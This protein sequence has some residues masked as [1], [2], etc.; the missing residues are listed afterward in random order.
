[1]PTFGVNNFSKGLDTKRHLISSEAGE[2]QDLVN[3]HVN[4]GG[5]IEKRR[6][7][8]Q[9]GTQQCTTVPGTPGTDGYYTT[10]NQWVVDVPGIPATWVV[11][12]PYYQGDWVV[13]EP[14]H[15]D[16]GQ[17]LCPG[18]AGYDPNNSGANGGTTCYT[19]GGE[20]VPEVG[21]YE[22]ATDEQ[23]HW[24]GGQAEVG[25]WEEEQIWHPPVPG[26]PDVTTCVPSNSLPPGTFG[27]EITGSGIFVFGSIPQ[28]TWT[29]PQD[30]V[31]QRLQH[32]DGFAMTGVRWS[33][34]YGAKP[35]VLAEF[36]NG[37]V[38]PYYNG[39]AVGSFVN[40]IVRQ[41]MNNTEGVVDHFK[42]LFDTAIAEALAENSVLKHYTVSKLNPTT[43]RLTGKQGVPF[44]VSTEAEAPMTIVAT[45]V[46]EATDDVLERV[47]VARVTISQGTNGSARTS[48][49]HRWSFYY[50]GEASWTPRITGIWIDEDDTEL[51]QLGPGSPGLRADTPVFG[52]AA[53]QPVGSGANNMAKVIAYYINQLTET[54]E[55][56]AAY[57]YGG[58]E[59][60]AD[61]GTLTI[62]AP[63][64]YAESGNDTTIWFEFDADPSPWAGEWS[65]FGVDTS[66]IQVS[67][68]NPGRWYAKWAAAF[69]GGA[70]NSIS[71]FMVESTELMKA[72]EDVY[73]KTS[74]A[75][76]ADDLVAAINENLTSLDPTPD[77]ILS[78]ENTSTIVVTARPGTGASFNG[79]RLYVSTEGSVGTVGNQAFAGGRDGLPGK[80]QI[81]DFTFGGFSL[82][83]KLTITITDSMLTGYP[84]Q[85]GASWLAGKEPSFT[86]TYKA[87][88]FAGIDY[89][90][91][92]S[93]LNDCTQWD[94]YDNGAG[95]INL[96][97]NFSGRDPLTGVGVY[98][99]KLAIF[100]RRNIQ[101]FDINYDPTQDSQAQV[102][103]GSGTIAPGSVVSAN[104]LDLF[105][106]ADNGIRSVK[107]RQNTVSAYADDI[108]TPI[109]T[110]VIDKLSTMTEDQ[111]S[112]AVAIIE[113]VEGRYWLVLGDQ[114]YVLSMYS[115]SQIFAWSRYE[116]G[117]NIE[118]LVN[119]DNLVYA[120]SGD[121]I[122]IYGGLTGRQ[123]D[124]CQVV[125]ELPYM[126]GG[127]PHVYKQTS[128]IDLTIDGT[129]TVS[130]GF[131]YTAPNARD[132]ICTTGQSTY[133]LG[134][135]PMNGVGTHL[136]IKLVSQS[137]GP[138]KISNIVVHFRELHSRGS[139]G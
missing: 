24:E 26:T 86:Y 109:D 98:Q 120:R 101:L 80:P 20:W 87:K 59:K 129:W 53:S 50:S 42:A 44:E 10:H 54:T 4:R 110:L 84:Y 128:G 93:R 32:P 17:T 33:S 99:D 62:Y 104:S 3:A 1:M 113:P 5:E 126:D 97:N 88:K 18:D 138:A 75:Q 119:K 79:R 85:I 16:N 89:S 77:Y 71:S 15:Y 107:S 100:S 46:Q 39:V 27:L 112:K 123:Y 135:I 115:G 90:I 43:V 136:G 114:I 133:A 14:G 35:F 11:D 73:W 22:N 51:I 94:I 45:K 131:D 122:Y 13:D 96:S 19:E 116:P 130:A 81:T 2:L 23:G 12:V 60:K 57:S 124:S 127:S 91:Y 117:F 66:T 36:S 78:V 69:S 40:G 6:A 74:N 48:A 55:Y 68:R 76:L 47:A 63:Q 61:P 108:G 8:V 105:Y 34:V 41:Y 65:Q 72:G 92:F 25:H 134:I 37:D 70:R 67:P 30:V 102:I 121:N 82:N 28:P 58:R 56:Y 111:K 103:D 106:L 21:H 83:K 95:F 125:A 9:I 52:P 38:I 118:W 49:G 137:P 139:A 64:R 132:V 31:Y 29:W 7:F